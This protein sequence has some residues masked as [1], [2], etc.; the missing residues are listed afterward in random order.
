MEI[1]NYNYG[2]VAQGV[3]HSYECYAG[4]TI[5]ETKQLCYILS[6]GGTLTW[7]QA[8]SC[9]SNIGG[10]LLDYN[11]VDNAFPLLIGSSSSLRVW[12]EVSYSGS[13]WIDLQNTVISPNWKSGEPSLTIGGCGAAERSPSNPQFLALNCNNAEAYICQTPVP[14][15]S[16]IDFY[17]QRGSSYF[18]ASN[19]SD[20]FGPLGVTPGT[21]KVDIFWTRSQDK[22]Y[23]KLWD[24][25][26]LSNQFT[27]YGSQPEEGF[28]ASISYLQDQVT[29]HQLF[30][31]AV[32]SYTAP[33]GCNPSGNLNNGKVYIYEGE[34]T[35]WTANQILNPPDIFYEQ[36]YFGAHI[37]S[38][39]FHLHSLA[40]GCTGC[41]YTANS[42]A[43][44]VYDANPSTSD[45]SQTQILISSPTAYTHLAANNVK[46]HNNVIISDAGNN[47]VIWT[48]KVSNALQANA[49]P[50][51]KRHLVGSTQRWSQQQALVS[52]TY[53][54][55]SYDIFDDTIVIGSNNVPFQ[56]YVSVGNVYICYP[57]TSEFNLTP[58]KPQPMQWSVQQILW[59]PSPASNIQFGSG[60]SISGDR[61]LVLGQGND[62]GFLYARSNRAGHWSLQQTIYHGSNVLETVLEGS[63]F[64]SLVSSLTDA[65][66]VYDQTSLW[67]CLIISVEDQFGDGWDSAKLT[68][69]TPVGPIKDEFYPRCD[70]ENPFQ[71]RYCPSNIDDSGIYTF[72][73]PKGNQAK[74]HWEIIWRVFLESSGEWI[75]GNWET[76][77][78]FEWNPNI[79]TFV[80]RKV[81]KKLPNNVT[82]V[83]CNPRPTEKP[84]PAL[85]YLKGADGKTRHPTI[86]PAPTLQVLE[87]SIWQYL[88]VNGGTDD[89][90]F[91]NHRSTSYYISDVEGLRL[92]AVGSLC[93]NDLA[94]TKLCWQDLH[95]GEY[96][97]RLGGALNPYSDDDS[98]TWCK[99]ISPIM[100]QSQLTVKIS[101]DDCEMISFVTR[102]YFC[103]TQ[104]D[105]DT[106]VEFEIVLYGISEE[107]SSVEISQ[108][109]KAL[110]SVF[111]G[112]VSAHIVSSTPI[113]ES[114]HLVISADFSAIRSGYDMTNP[115]VITSIESSMR[116]TFSSSERAF[117]AALISSDYKS[118][119]YSVSQVSFV[120]LK[121]HGGER[122]NVPL[123]EI[124]EEVAT[125]YPQ[126]YEA[127][128]FQ[129]PF[130]VSVGGFLLVGLSVLMVSLFIG[131]RKRQGFNAQGEQIEVEM[132]TNTN[133]ISMSSHSSKTK[134]KVSS[135]KNGN[136]GGGF[137]DGMDLNLHQLNELAHA[138]DKYL[139]I[140]KQ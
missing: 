125:F 47:L 13:N 81:A 135:I 6:P 49:F 109:A 4:W 117:W 36:S 51:L 97:L 122:A 2:R 10:Q 42:G 53:S 114:L 130:L 79:A 52:K 19:P 43:I 12:T 46:I 44:F 124:A 96:V 39:R 23:D 84:T 99:S 28:G 59:P 62:L 105:F 111:H 18:I 82:C 101:D 60:V 29:K 24:N 86:S 65:L 126:S 120:S 14:I 76:I 66:E 7:A 127:E 138:E 68:V 95:D 11:N 131:V 48:K 64:Y 20:L 88:T 32:A 26:P 103:N 69:S 34:Y 118:K 107:L 123:S 78:D 72:S 98:L 110:D 90:F 22:I 54:L 80:T 50:S 116:T 93:P 74:Y 100:S 30:V 137:M 112:F 56:G 77:M 119:L 38:D 133:T 21:G 102:E 57:S 17:D 35:K 85:R 75:V 16:D 106:I 89:W 140:N 58:K 9:C 63:T 129:A 41:N 31:G 45:W 121:F 33:V 139:S 136:R 40:V 104:L 15:K 1:H 70:L 87:G 27:I 128:K 5:D 94:T 37:D 92:F 3:Y 25:T 108:I 55:S 73:I 113:G 91:D 67:N 61:M 132:G 134:K 115:S 8:K 83:S 71:F